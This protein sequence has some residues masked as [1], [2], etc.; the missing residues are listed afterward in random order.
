MSIRSICT[1]RGTARRSSSRPPR[2]WA[3]GRRHPASDLGRVLLK[4]EELQDEQIRQALEPTEAD[5]AAE[6]RKSAPRR[7]RCCSDPRLLERILDDFARCGVV[8]EETNKLV[9]YLAA[10]SRHLEAPLAVWC[11]QSRPPA[12]VR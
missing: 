12:R 4:L 9:G 2:S 1:R 10:V 8:G 3:R 7:W 5:G 6:P 11:N